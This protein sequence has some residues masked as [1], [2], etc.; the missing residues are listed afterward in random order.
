MSDKKTHELTSARE[1]CDLYSI[2]FDTTAKVM[3]ILNNH[4]ILESVKGIKGG[5]LLNADLS[6]FSFLKLCQMIEGEQNES[7]CSSEK[8]VCELF[9]CCNIKTPI[10]RLNRSLLEF[11]K[12]ITISDLFSGEFVP[13]IPLDLNSPSKKEL[14]L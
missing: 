2:P 12:Q 8:K 6:S 13:F 5:Y 7:F 14:Q 1:I 9:D 11:F 10:D 4:Q 3:Q